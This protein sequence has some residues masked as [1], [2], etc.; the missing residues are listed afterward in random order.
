[1]HDYVLGMPDQIVNVDI[2]AEDLRER[3][4]AGK[5]YPRER[6]DTALENFSRRRT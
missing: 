5:A 1:V 4:Q 3:L 6:I 2:S